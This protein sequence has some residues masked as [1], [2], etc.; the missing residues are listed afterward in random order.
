[1]TTLSASGVMVD[2]VGLTASGRRVNV[3][4]AFAA[5]PVPRASSTVDQPLII[6]DDITT[7]GATLAEA[8]R[9]LITAGWSVR[10]SA[11]VAQTVARMGVAARATRG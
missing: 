7:T 9:A 8:E 2:Q 5:T 6:V 11:V 10:G 4:G 1:M 3:A